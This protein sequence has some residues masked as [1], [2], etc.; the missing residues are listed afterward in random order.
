MAKDCWTKKKPIESNTATSSSKENSEDGWDAEA[1][2][3]TEE[4]ELALTVTTPEQIDYKN[5]WIV[6]SG[7]SNDMTGDK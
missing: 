2:F 7:C 1:L 5:D 6:D 4:E 3:A